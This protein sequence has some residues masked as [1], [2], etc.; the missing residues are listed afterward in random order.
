MLDMISYDIIS[1]EVQPHLF[2]VRFIIFQ[3][4]PPFLKCLLT[5][6][7]IIDH[8]KQYFN[9]HIQYTDTLNNGK[10]Y[11]YA[12]NPS[13][14]F[15]LKHITVYQH[16]ICTVPL[17]S[18]GGKSGSS[19]GFPFIHGASGDLY[20]CIIHVSSF[21]LVF[22]LKSVSNGRI[23]RILLLQLEQW[24]TPGCLG[25]RGDYTTQLYGDFNNLRIP[26]NQPV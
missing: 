11:K 5:S 10:V 21:I 6:R 14:A 15:M 16:T 13:F 7:D 4:E 23:R 22:I 24:K 1:L 2:I 8:M 18:S 9:I 19:L 20:T 12:Y 26:I 25:Y 3:K 17:L